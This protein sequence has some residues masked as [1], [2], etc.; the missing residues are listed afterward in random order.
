MNKKTNKIMVIVSLI[1]LL[2]LT[3]CTSNQ[4]GG[5]FKKESESSGSLKDLEKKEIAME[6]VSSA[7]NSSLDWKAQSRYIE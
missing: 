5:Q 7:E 1:G 4:T 2:V 6:L 3:G